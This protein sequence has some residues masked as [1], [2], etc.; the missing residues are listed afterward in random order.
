MRRVRYAVGMSLDAYIADPADGVGW[1]IGDP[2]YDGM[3]FFREIDTALMGRRTFEVAVRQGGGAMPGIRGYVF[4]RTLRAEDFP[5]VT[6][7]ADDAAGVVAA[8]RAE[9]TG[10]DIWLAGG[11]ELF[12][13]LAEAGLVDTVEIGLN[14]ILLGGGIPLAPSLPRSVRLE[15]TESTA[16]PGGLVILRYDV[17]REG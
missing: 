10:R 7:V 3:A 12:G 8:L 4:S 1:M 17:R 14:P 13:S 11:G 6:V 15:L 9:D 2:E 16:Y 5:D